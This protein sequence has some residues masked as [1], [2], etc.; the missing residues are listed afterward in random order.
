[1]KS[2]RSDLVYFQHIWP[3]LSGKSRA[4]RVHVAL[5]VSYICISSVGPAFGLKMQEEEPGWS[6]ALITPMKV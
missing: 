1:M 6:S 5:V 3:F 2:R 4:R